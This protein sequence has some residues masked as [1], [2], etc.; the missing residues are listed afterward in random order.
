MRDEDPT[1][2]CCASEACS[3]EFPVEGTTTWCRVVDVDAG[4]HLFGRHPWKMLAKRARF[5]TVPGR[6]LTAWLGALGVIGDEAEEPDAPW[7][8][9]PRSISPVQILVSDPRR[10]FGLEPCSSLVDIE[11]VPRSA[12]GHLSIDLDLRLFEPPLEFGRL[13]VL[14]DG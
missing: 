4:G 8:L 13:R 9:P 11:L 3:W 14:G 10:A 7:E 5:S 12:C 1:A 2:N 6:P